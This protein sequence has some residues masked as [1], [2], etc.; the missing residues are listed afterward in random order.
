M[1]IHTL[2]QGLRARREWP[3]LRGAAVLDNVHKQNSARL[4]GTDRV[5]TVTNKR[6]KVSESSTDRS[7]YVC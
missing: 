6:V 5:R 2:V 4:L 3:M 1:I 7:P